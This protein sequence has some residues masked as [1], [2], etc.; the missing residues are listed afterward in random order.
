MVHSK[1]A[2][3]PGILNTH[4]N[5]HYLVCLL[6]RGDAVTRPFALAAVL[7]IR[8]FFAVLP[9]GASSSSLKM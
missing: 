9:P 8:D 4:V 1:Y 3:M 7:S 6:P 2:P 5:I